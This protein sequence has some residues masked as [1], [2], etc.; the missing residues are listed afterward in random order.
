MKYKSMQELTRLSGS[1]DV[2][3]KTTFPSVMKFFL[4]EVTMYPFHIL[5]KMNKHNPNC[6]VLY[7]EATK[8]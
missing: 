4:N 7:A 5:P 3:F 6:L 8:S 2:H 1:R